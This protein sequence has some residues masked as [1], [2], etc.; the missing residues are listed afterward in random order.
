NSAAKAAQILYHESSIAVYWG[1]LLQSVRTLWFKRVS[2]CPSD[3][4]CILLFSSAAEATSSN[5]PR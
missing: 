5:I 3:S 1:I 2:R 4:V